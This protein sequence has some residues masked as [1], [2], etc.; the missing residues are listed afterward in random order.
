VDEDE[1]DEELTKPAALQRYAPFWS[2]YYWYNNF[3]GNS[4][5]GNGSF[6]GGSAY[7]PGVYNQGSTGAYST[8]Y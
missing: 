4:T 7:N 6:S 1:D 3:Y 2:P 8:Y 5:Y